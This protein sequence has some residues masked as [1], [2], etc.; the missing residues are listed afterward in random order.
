M[1]KESGWER[2]KDL[3]DRRDGEEVAEELQLW[4]VMTFAGSCVGFLFGGLMGARYAADEH[5]KMNKTTLYPNQMQAQRELH[6]ASMMGMARMGARWGWRLGAFAGLFSAFNIAFSV[7]RDRNDAFNMAAAGGITG[8]IFRARY[9]LK[10]LMGGMLLGGV[11]SF[12][13]GLL[14]QGVD[15]LFLPEEERVARKMKRRIDKE[16]RLLKRKEKLCKVQSLVET[17]EEEL[18]VDD[19]RDASAFGLSQYYTLIGDNTGNSREDKSRSDSDTFFVKLWTK[20][21]DACT[22]NMSK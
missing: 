4:P 7:Y 10:P 8:G 12:P 17:M 11:V 15:S 13:F 14:L 1:E 5:V 2:L 3:F 19:N 22:R 21:K 9:G 20:F 18:A 16:E 6:S